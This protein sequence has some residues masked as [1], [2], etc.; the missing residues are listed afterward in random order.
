MS[1]VPLDQAKAHVLANVAPLAPL[2][3]PVGSALGL[4]A[5]ESVPA[6]SPFPPFDNTAVDG[7]AV[8][9]ADVSGASPST[10][11]RL[12]IV[13]TAAAGA[14]PATP[15][16][17]AEA[18]RIMTGAPIPEGADAVVMVERTSESGGWVDV[19]EPV[20]P[21]ANIRRA[22]SDVR[23]GDVVVAPGTVLGPAHLA[24]LATAGRATVAVVPRPRVG[25]LST[26]DELVPPGEPLG[27]GQI[28]DSNRIALIGQIRLAG[29]E[30]LD[31]GCV[32]D[33]PAAIEEALRDGTASCDAL[34]T[35]GGVSMGEFDYLKSVLDRIGEMRWMQLAIKPAK[36]FAFG[37]VAGKPVFGLP[38]NPVSS[39]VSFELLARPALAAMSGRSEIERVPVMAVADEPFRRKEDGKIHFVR[40]Q[41][42]RGGKGELRVRSAGGQASYQL[43]AM[44]AAN[45]LAVLENGTGV[46]AGEPVPCLLLDR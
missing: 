23:A 28:Y 22:A 2:T 19:L 32:R 10:P 3:V 1:L 24:L 46:D 38:G 11:A 4:V 44:A 17:A 12:R 20:A 30:P 5:A 7:F 18:I 15:V 25:V 36:P 14:A 41:A 31:L 8:R 9:A 43:T 27:P 29:F 33:D 34:V 42:S 21:A 37:T 26:G 45:A 40:V 13:G 6:S 39:M 16:G 35:S